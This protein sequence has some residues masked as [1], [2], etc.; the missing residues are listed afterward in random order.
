MTFDDKVE[1]HRVASAK[2]QPYHPQNLDSCITQL[3]VQ[4]PSRTCN[5]SKEEEEEEEESNPKSA[6]C[7]LPKPQTLTP[8]ADVL[9]LLSTYMYTYTLRYHSI[10]DRLRV[11]TTRAEDAQGT[12]TQSHISPRILVYEDKL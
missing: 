10:V 12:P 1:L 8:G 11:G 9:E 3:K 6:K 2:C 7:Q 4:G 5:E